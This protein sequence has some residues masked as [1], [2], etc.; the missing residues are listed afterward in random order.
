MVDTTFFR[1]EWVMIAL[2]VFAVFALLWVVKN[3][4]KWLLIIA[5]IAFCLW[6]F[7]LA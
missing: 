4:I 5:I 3:L 2:A 6:K 1:Q 7:W